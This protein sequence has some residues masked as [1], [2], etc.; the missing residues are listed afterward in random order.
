MNETCFLLNEWFNNTFP[1]KGIESFSY[2]NNKK[3]INILDKYI[4]SEN[5]FIDKLLNK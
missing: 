5:K 1:V 2:D 4:N 3:S